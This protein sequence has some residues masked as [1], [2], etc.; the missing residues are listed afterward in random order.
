MKNF[1]NIIFTTAIVF[2]FL[3]GKSQDQ[4]DMQIW[5]KLSPEIRLNIKDTPWEFRVRP[6]DHII[7]PSINIGRTD[8]MIGANFKPFKIFSYSKFDYTGRSWTGARL[9][10]NTAIINKKL[11]INIQERF[12]FGLNEDSEMHYYLIQFIRYKITPKIHAGVLSYGKWAVEEPFNEA[13][14]FVGPTVNFEFPYKF[15][16][17]LAFNK[18][19]FYKDIY[20]LFVRLGYR[21]VI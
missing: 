20:M 2:S 14:W 6:D 3:A 7:L 18:D 15:N 4:G 5:Y 13:H 21:I 9:D 16:L 1:K 17:H 19:V 10:Y 12:F 8:I 11:L